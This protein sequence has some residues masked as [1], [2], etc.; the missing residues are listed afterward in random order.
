MAMTRIGLPF[1]P[2]R[3]AF[4]EKLVAVGVTILA[5]VGGFVLFFGLSGM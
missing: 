1:P 4:G 3:I 5:V 2:K